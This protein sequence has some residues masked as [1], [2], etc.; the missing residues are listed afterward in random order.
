[1]ST[2]E[3]PLLSEGP[4]PLDHG[5]VYDRFSPSK[6]RVILAMVSCSGVIPL[7]VS[8]VFI[9]AIPQ[10]ARDLLTTP[11]VASLTITTSYVGAS[12]GSMVMAT[13]SGF[14]GRRPIY[15][16]GLP[17]FCLG[18]YQIAVTQNIYHLIAWRFIQNVGISASISLG[19]G[20]IGDVYKLEERGFPLGLFFGAS[21]IGP[22]IAPVSGGIMA[23]YASWRM[24]QWGF[25]LYGLIILTSMALWLPE[26]S[27]PGTLGIE[28]AEYHHHQQQG[29]GSTQ[30]RKWR[31]IATSALVLLTEFGEHP[32]EWIGMANKASR[33]GLAVLLV[34][35]AYTIGAEYGIVNEA[36]IG[37]VFIPCG[38]GNM[39]GAPLAG[40]VSDR[41]IIAHRAK[42]GG[43]WCPEDRLRGALFSAATFV[44]LS[45]LFIGLT[46]EFIPGRTGLLLCLV[47]L[48][49]NGVG[50]HLVLSPLAVYN[51]DIM[52]SRSTEIIAAY[53]GTRGM[54][55]SLLIPCIL[56]S[57]SHFGVVATNAAAALVAWAGFGT[58]VVIIR[59]GGQ[60]RAW[61]DIGYTTADSENI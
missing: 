36:L 31:W 8:G 35:L 18:S 26:T 61:K 42:R 54:F 29:D 11:E 37:A 34:P 10:I 4:A 14:Y 21:L 39:V 57:I 58:L 16:V 40:Y 52:Q 32:Y 30:R 59:Y 23:H 53:T 25:L 60:L 47:W 43:E 13:Y 38:V 44:P 12:L 33:F 55:I 24:L 15:L 1:M 28:Q 48:F 51:I 27:H 49:M 20:V 50:I 22:A 3:T 5:R 6:K 56:P 17:F 41:V 7:F 2:E 46:V 9:P 45:V 19:A